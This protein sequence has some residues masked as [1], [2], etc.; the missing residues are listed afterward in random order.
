MPD[1]KTPETGI[2]KKVLII[3]YYWPPSGGAGVQR[4]LKFV[5]YLRAFGWEPIVHTPENPEPPEFDES[6]LQDMPDGITVIRRPVWEPYS[7]YKWLTGQKKESRITHGFLKEESRTGLAE[8][9]SVWIR[10]NFFIPDAR[11]FWIKPSVR[12]LTKYFQNQTIDAIVSSGPPHSMH[13]IALGLKKKINIPW[14]ADFRDPWTEIDF[15]N[16][17]MLTRFADHRH[18]MLERKVLTTADRVL[19]IGNHL[20]G[21]LQRLGAPKVDVITNGFDEDDFR[22]LPVSLEKEFTITYVGSVNRDRNPEILWQAIA[23]V[24]A[25]NSDINSLLKLRFVGKTDHSLRESM[26]RNGLEGRT[27]F[28]AYLPHSEA[29]RLAASSAVLLLLINRTP[30]QDG[31]VTGKLFEY[32]A[33]QR[34]VLCIGPTGGEVATILKKTKAGVVCDYE[35]KQCIKNQLIA[36]F[37]TWKTNGSLKQAQE[38]KDYSRVNLTQKVAAILDEMVRKQLVRS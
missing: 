38:I 13:L 17:L 24:C 25:E 26:V 6:L 33:T 3:T 18:K 7:F 28:I 35:D 14:L 27:K 12:F 10:G 30:N 5:K 32:L 23:E 2:M 16:K 19:T 22:F 34:P 4:W 11:C 9:L 1:A 20:A 37:I 8:K 21:R 29:L 31:I 15:Y 36:L